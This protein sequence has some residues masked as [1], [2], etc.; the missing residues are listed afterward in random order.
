MKKAYLIPK[1]IVIKVGNEPADFFHE[2]AIHPCIAFFKIYH[3]SPE[4]YDAVYTKGIAETTL[5]PR[6]LVVLCDQLLKPG[7]RFEMHYFNSRFS[8]GI[9]RPFDF[10]AQELS[11]IIGDRYRLE[12]MRFDDDTITMTWRKLKGTLPDNDR[13]TCWSFGIISNGSKNDWVLE[14][15][16]QILAM[17]ISECEIIVCGPVPGENLPGNVRV[18]SDDDLITDDR[19]PICKKKNKIIL[20][21]KYNNLVLTHDR[22]RF[23]EDWYRKM[24]EYGNYFDVLCT[25]ITA[26]NNSNKRVRDWVAFKGSMSDYKSCDAGIVPYNEWDETI[27][28]DG[29]YLIGKTHQLRKVLYDVRLHWGEAEDVNFS[30]RLYLQGIMTNFYGD[31]HVL[32]MT[33][34]HKGVDRYNSRLNVFRVLLR[35][36]KLIV[37][38]QEQKKQFLNYLKRNM[39]S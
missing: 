33:H 21:A 10:M 16:K 22:I 26:I 29:G 13:I 28:I 2:D 3:I 18:L 23:P 39:L 17:K 4:I 19:A 20:A 15:I 25:R 6:Q 8:K 11:L 12:K 38:R 5:Y 14:M 34:R 7:G 32:S 1:G 30:K 37:K 9:V 36:K 27:F 35:K 24:C 31:C